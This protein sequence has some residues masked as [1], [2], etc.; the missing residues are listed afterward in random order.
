MQPTQLY[1]NNLNGNCKR[2]PRALRDISPGG[3]CSSELRRRS[4]ASIFRSELRRRS[5]MVPIE[6]RRLPCSMPSPDALKLFSRQALGPTYNR[7]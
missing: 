5:A 3:P 4:V 1:D 2:F 6:L 7:L